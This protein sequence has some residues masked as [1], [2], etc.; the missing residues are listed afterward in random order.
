MG[1]PNRQLDVVAQS[2]CSPPVCRTRS[3]SLL[4]WDTTIT[5]DTLEHKLEMFYGGQLRTM[6]QEWNHP[7]IVSVSL[8]W[9]Q[10]LAKCCLCTTLLSS[11]RC[12]ER[13][14]VENEA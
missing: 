8:H 1:Y 5:H 10:R 12:S 11:V 14:E 7:R 2:A 13:F 6:L 4:A 9:L 3:G